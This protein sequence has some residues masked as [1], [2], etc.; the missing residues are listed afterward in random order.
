MLRS[1]I[2]PTIIQGG[3]RVNV[4]PSEAK[5]TLDVRLVPGEDTAAF[6]ASCAR[7]STIRPFDVEWT[8]RDVRPGTPRARLDS[9]V[10]RVLESACARL[11]DATVLP[12]MSTGA[13][14][15]AYLRDKGIQCYGVGP[16]LTWRTARRDSARTAIRSG[17]SKGSCTGSCASTTRWHEILHAHQ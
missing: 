12:T 11:Y 2:S 8:P 5:A 6:L 14:D 4:I 3:Y 13:T 9:E 16:A 10:F 17:F 1:S 15:M 7:S